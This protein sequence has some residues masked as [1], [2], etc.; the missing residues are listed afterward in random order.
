MRRLIAVICLLLLALS[1]AAEAAEEEDWNR[2]TARGKCLFV[3]S[4]ERDDTGIPIEVAFWFQ[5]GRNRPIPCKISGQE[6]TALYNYHRQ[7]DGM[8]FRVKITGKLIFNW[9]TYSAKI[10]KWELAER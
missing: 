5:T 7:N 10:G 3:Y 4:L 1:I 9:H 6:A 2:W 8:P